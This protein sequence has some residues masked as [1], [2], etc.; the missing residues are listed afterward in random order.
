MSERDIRE[1]LA[2]NNIEKLIMEYFLRNISVGEI[3]A[4][5]DLREEVKKR[6]KTGELQYSDTDDAVIEREL[7]TI[8]TSLIRR[9]FLE[10]NMGVFNLAEWIREYLRKKY[11]SLETGVS[12]SLEKIVS[13]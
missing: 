6:I 11:K 1:L 13:D 7:L 5:L 2:L 3:I 12:K 4:I 10:Y 8:I 9:G